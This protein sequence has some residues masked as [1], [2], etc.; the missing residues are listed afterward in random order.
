MGPCGM[1]QQLQGLE[2]PHSSF[3]HAALCLLCP[4]DSHAFVLDKIQLQQKGAILILAVL[5][6]FPFT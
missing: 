1:S 2:R 4:H 5:W 3:Y 6:M